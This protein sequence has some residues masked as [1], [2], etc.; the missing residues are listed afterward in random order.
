[1]YGLN[2]SVPLLIFV[3][4]FV[5][6]NERQDTKNSVIALVFVCSPTISN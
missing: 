1:M 6:K 4:K 2:Q 3:K 5:A